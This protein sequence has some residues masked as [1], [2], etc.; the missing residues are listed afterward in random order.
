M[1][2]SASNQTTSGRTEEPQSVPSQ[3]LA[4]SPAFERHF[5]VAEVAALWELSHDAVRRLFRK[6][7]GVVTFGTAIKGSKRRYTTMRIPESVLERVY[8]HYS[9]YLNVTTK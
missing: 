3:Q 6:E 8:K 5:T 4:S 2:T 9:L 1:R 7:P